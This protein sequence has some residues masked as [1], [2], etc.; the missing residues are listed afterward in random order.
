MGDITIKPAGNK[1]RFGYRGKKQRYSVFK[2]GVNQKWA[3][4]DEKLTRDL[5]AEH[6]L[7]PEAF[8][9]KTDNPNKQWTYAYIRCQKALGNLPCIDDFESAGRIWQKG[10]RR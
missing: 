5:C 1:S 8:L 2:A 4:V 6:D 3:P 9:C 10:N 7:V